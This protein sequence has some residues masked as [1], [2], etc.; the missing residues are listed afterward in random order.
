M[1]LILVSTLVLVNSDNPKNRIAVIETLQTS[2]IVLRYNNYEHFGI[3][4][5]FFISLRL[6]L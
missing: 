5:D 4:A 6:I 2:L 1:V 3:K